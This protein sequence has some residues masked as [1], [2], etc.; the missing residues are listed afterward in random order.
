VV[1]AVDGGLGRVTA[2]CTADSTTGIC[3][4]T[5]TLPG[6]WFASSIDS[7]VNVSYGFNLGSLVSA[8][9]VVLRQRGTHSVVNNVVI[10]LPQGN[11]FP[12]DTFTVGVEGHGG[13]ALSTFTLKV[14][15]SSSLRIL[16]SSVP[17]KWSAVP[18]NDGSVFAITGQLADPSSAPS[19]Q[20]PS[21]VLFTLT[22]QV[23]SNAA[24][25]AFARVSGSI[26][27]LTDTRSQS[28][29]A[30]TPSPMTF[31]DRAGTWV[32]DGSV[33][34]A[35]NRIVGLLPYVQQAELVNTA[36][37]D[38][39]TVSTALTVPGVFLSG[40]IAPVSSGLTCTSNT[41]V[42]GVGGSCG[43]VFLS[44]TEQGSSEAT[45][46]NVS[47]N[48]GATGRLPMRVWRPSSINVW[49]DDTQ[50]D[51]ILDYG[52]ASSGC[53][54]MYQQTRVR[55]SATFVCGAQPPFSASISNMIAGRLSS[56]NSLV[57]VA[58][59]NGVVRGL[60][61]GVAAISVTGGAGSIG[62]VVVTAGSGVVTVQQLSLKLVQ[63]LVVSSVPS[64]LEAHSS[65]RLSVSVASLLTQEYQQAYVQAVSYFDDGTFGEVDSSMGLRLVSG[66]PNVV[67]ISG[68]Y[69]VA[70]G[71]GLVAVTGLWN[72]SCFN[73]TLVQGTGTASVTLP[74]PTDVI[75]DQ[76]SPK[77]TLSGN[78]AAVVP[79]G[80]GTSSG[81]RVQ[82]VFGSRTQDMTADTRTIY[83]ASMSGGLFSVVMVNGM[84]G[85]VANGLGL[86]GTGT[87]IVQ[88]SHVNI[89][90]AVAIQI[91][92]AS[93]MTLSASP[94][95]TYSGS[96]SVSVG[97]VR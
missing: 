55:G 26:I 79:S 97:G 75:V 54:Q 44:G 18:S 96:G 40:T 58:G 52:D 17:N 49:A 69:V 30:T 19:G 60:G 22:M 57:A 38:A 92:V 8:G 16:S 51:A 35:A 78:A 67:S 77:L 37:I 90:R 47:H 85:I 9:S 87:L 48:S 23:Q 76:F 50:L 56:N 95:P 34:V 93:A 13:L 86:F 32:A 94:F 43:N 82:L 81:I 65:T 66:N 53:R 71:S 46:I 91:V 27:S 21:E 24:T 64:T 1:V 80:L 84:P 63:S 4:A 62:Q 31:E 7:S 11:L 33:F 39:S 5:V 72:S 28:V 74:A 6:T 68:Q 20:Q 10:A 25:D 88:F 89:S 14:N 12:G 41:N 29:F 42:V 83:N 73:R 61:R 45:W 2:S 70:Q 36:V 15:V 59:S 3:L